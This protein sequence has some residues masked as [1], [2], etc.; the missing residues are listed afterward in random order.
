MQAQ[1]SRSALI[2]DHH[3][4]VWKASDFPSEP[5]AAA[6]ISIADYQTFKK[7]ITGTAIPAAW[8]TPQQL[9]KK[10]YRTWRQFWLI[11]LLI[12]WG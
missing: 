3:C 2:Q 1:S 8:L 5:P 6:D 12:N 4:E 11:Q 9:K 10:G 7:D